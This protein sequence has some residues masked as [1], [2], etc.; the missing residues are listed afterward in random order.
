MTHVI[1]GARVE[2]SEI[3]SAK[4]IRGVKTDTELLRLLI[5]EASRRKSQ[6]R[7]KRK[8]A[9]EQPIA[10]RAK[11]PATEPAEEDD[12]DKAISKLRIWAF[13]EKKA[14]NEI[15]KDAL[16]DEIIN[17]DYS[18]KVITHSKEIIEAVLS[19]LP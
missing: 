12:I 14:G 10:V 15:D 1:I 8:P 7:A 17:G 5:S 3:I 11:L 16:I 9:D 18:E 2:E 13:D 19:W 6:K 4:K